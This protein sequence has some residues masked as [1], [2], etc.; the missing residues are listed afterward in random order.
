M[1]GEIARPTKLLLAFLVLFGSC[2]RHAA[3]P[4]VDRIAILRFEDLSQDNSAD[5]MGRAF[6]DVITAELSGVPGINSLRASWLHGF[7]RG[8]GVRPISAPGISSE[9]MQALLAGAHHI[10]YGEYTI[11]GGRV[12][13]RLTMENAATGKM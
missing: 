6:S 1:A 13:A 2:A 4:A 11:R 10:G 8:L 7:D 12:E 9:R 3:G 5:W